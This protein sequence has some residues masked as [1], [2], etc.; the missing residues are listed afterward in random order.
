VFKFTRKKLRYF[1]FFLAPV[2]ILI[3]LSAV[4][5]GPIFRLV[6]RPSIILTYLN[7]E[8]GG[9]IFY[10]RNLTENEKLKKD[11]DLLRQKI[12]NL[13]EIYLENMRLKELLSLKQSSPL[14]VIAARVIATSADNW[15]S[16]L[17]LD[18]G[19]HHGI[20]RNMAV[21]NYL[22]L[23]G[24]VVES[25]QYTSKVM[26]I[27][28]SN[29]GV[30]GMVQRSRQEGLVSGAMGRNLVM[31]YLPEGADIAVSDTIVTSG[32]NSIYPKGLLIGKVVEVGNE[33]S[34]LSR[35]AA[36]K[37]A[38]IFSSIEEVLVVVE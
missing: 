17:L 9:F 32:S 24:R 4:L 26:L 6:R 37:P 33:F 21:I 15:S 1:V 3:L 14:K 18:K 27:T 31:H 5:I 34:G 20:R 2:V 25:S 29:M 19:L 11:V 38:V 23:V 16:M 28:D 8:L 10:H 12:H 22:G 13:N 36:I 7:R 30:S 35:Y